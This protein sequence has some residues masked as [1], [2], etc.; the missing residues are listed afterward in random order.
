MNVCVSQSRWLINVQKPWNFKPLA[1]QNFNFRFPDSKITDHFVW[2][3]VTDIITKS[4]SIP[5]MMLCCEEGIL[6]GNLMQRPTAEDP[7]YDLV[8]LRRSSS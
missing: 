1:D 5:V 2:F 3:P 4:Q 7:S 6:H 8:F